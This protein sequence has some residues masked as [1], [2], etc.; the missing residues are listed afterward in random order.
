M[1][2][3]VYKQVEDIKAQITV[4]IKEAFDLAE[5]APFPVQSEA[6]EGVYA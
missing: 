2:S 4:D 5:S 6:Y 1:P 3:S